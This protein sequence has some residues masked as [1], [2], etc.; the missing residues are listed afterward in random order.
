MRKLIYIS[1]LI[2]VSNCV[3]AQ[4]L[5]QYTQYVYNP[6]LFNPSEVV[7]DN[8]LSIVGNLRTQWAGLDGAPSTQAVGVLAPLNRDRIGL[9][10]QLLRSTIG[11]QEKLDANAMYAYKLRINEQ[12]SFAL[13]IQ[14][15]V[16]RF[17]NDFTDPRLIALDGILADPSVYN[18]ILTKTILNGGLGF[19]FQTGKTY[20]A[21]SV[22]R[23][24]KSSIDS[25][26]DNFIAREIRH[27]YVSAGSEINI[28]SNWNFQPHTLIKYAEKSP[29][30]IDIWTGFIYREQI[31]LATNYS[32]GGRSSQLL[33]SI[34]MI[35][36]LKI[37]ERIFASLAFDFT[38]TPLKDYENGSFELF[39][40]YTLGP[41]KLP[42][43]LTDNPREF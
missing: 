20:V 32:F 37:N 4:Q 1:I 12:T 7:S 9:G 38:L 30:T 15:N 8:N 42:P 13:G 34:D 10:I 25:D 11:I 27:L 35:L 31:H 40:R 21:A 3:S 22:P 17:T 14:V 29:P 5:R 6:S 39:L 43:I 23:I 26:E 2:F 36:G 28:N 16:R 19:R 33:E 41:E 24:L 18:T